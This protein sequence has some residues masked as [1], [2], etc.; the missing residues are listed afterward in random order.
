MSPWIL[1]RARSYA[2]ALLVSG[3]VGLVCVRS[4]VARAGHPAVP[5]DDAFIHFQYAKRLAE[6]A[7]YNYVPGEGYSTGATSLLWP[8]ILAPFYAIGLKGLS[9]V[10]A[11]WA[12]GTLAHA[13]LV[14][15]AARLAERLAGRAA[16]AG[17]GAMCAAFGAFAWFAWSGM[18]T[19]PFAWVLL[20]TARVASDPEREGSFGLVLLGIA[21]PL[22]RP[23]GALASLIAAAGL[24]LGAPDAPRRSR[25]IALAP[26]VG[27][28]IM[29]GLHLALAG[30]AS[31]STATV[32]WLAM[33]PYFSRSALLGAIVDNAR[34]LVTSLLYGEDWTA[35]FLPEG[36]NV[37]I[38]LGLPALFVAGYRRQAKLCAAFVA[39]IALGA[40][41][42]CS[43]SSFLWNRVRYVWPFA[44]AWFVMLACLAR[45]VGDLAERLR[46]TLTY[47]TPLVCGVFVG[48][49][50]SRL[51]WAVRDLEDSAS[52]IDQQQAAL[53]RWASESLPSDARIGV[54]DTG[55]IAYLGGRATF[56]VVGLTT[57]GEARYWVAGAGSRFEH[58]E[59][60]PIERLPTHFIVYPHWMACPPVLGDALKEATVLDQ[61]ILGGPTMI[62]YE[63][64]YDRL[65]SGATPVSAPHGGELLDEL[66]VADLESEAAHAYSLEGAWDEENKAA[67]APPPKAA[68]GGEARAPSDVIA[69]GGRMNRARD[70]FRMARPMGSAADG[71]RAAL[72]LRASAD[73]AVKVT[74]SID[75]RVIGEASIPPGAWVE[76]SIEIPASAADAKDGALEIEVAAAQDGRFGSFH[77]WLYAF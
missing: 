26:L 77:Y 58:Y 72:I 10:W 3:A 64:R 29:P 74:A 61:S 2:L 52:A 18:E 75:G 50:A 33:S 71:R 30:H 68:D 19:I 44:G 59:R 27:P 28:L 13:G 55:A 14:V 22:L 31:S 12:L 60:M 65:G 8:L 40:L 15:E 48:A 32:K 46:P 37:P 56:D 49:L 62:A 76:R 67:L 57:E 38:L 73:A 4:I 11:A 5:L 36:S 51:P 39:I 21:A 47:V 25:W 69:D 63:A 9:L 45:E 53:A 42:P 34:L 35:L 17:A 70:R 43:Y 54:N 7:F 24:A 41:I 16:A 20:R 6:G 23:E 1:A 66:D